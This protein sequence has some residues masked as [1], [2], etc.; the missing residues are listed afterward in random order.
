MGGAIEDNGRKI[1]EMTETKFYQQDLFGLK[2]VDEA[3]PI[4]FEQTTG[5]HLQF[6]R[7]ELYGW[8]EKYFMS[9]DVIV[10]IFL[11]QGWLWFSAQSNTASNL[12]SQTKA[13]AMS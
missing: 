10:F 6:T 9:A 5:D 12:T 4:A 13:M 3:N 2:T 11:E 1:Q 8:V 7:D